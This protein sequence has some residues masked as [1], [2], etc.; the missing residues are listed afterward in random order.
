MS[1]LQRQAQL[2]GTNKPG[3]N[4]R[5]GSKKGS[6]S[7][8]KPGSRSESRAH[9]DVEDDEFQI[10]KFAERMNLSALSQSLDALSLQVQDEETKAQLRKT[11]YQENFETLLKD[12]RSSSL[13]QRQEALERIINHLVSKYDV[14]LYSHGDIET[15]N[16]AITTGR[17]AV[18]MTRAARALVIMALLDIED[19]CEFITSTTLGV[20]EPIISDEDQDPAIRSCLVTCYSLLMYYINLG[21]S[22][23]G[24]EPKIEMLLNIAT[25][26]SSSDSIVSC[27]ALLGIG[28]LTSVTASRNAVI[29]ETLPSIIELLKDND[30]DVRKTAGKNIAL[31]YELY[32]F[33]YQE[34]GTT[35]EDEYSGFKYGIDTVDTGDLIYDLK[36]LIAESAKSIARKTKSELRS[37][38]RKVLCTIEVRLVP[39]D[40]LREDE[41]KD[42]TDNEVAAEAISHLRLSK[43]KAIPI[44]T[45]NQLNLSSILKWLYADGLHTHVANNPLISESISNAGSEHLDRSK[46]NSGNAKSSG[47][48]SFDPNESKFTNK[49][50]SQK[51]EVSIKKGREMKAQAQAEHLQEDLVY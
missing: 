7:S 40:A 2:K 17:S 36:E 29:E 21:N 50:V 10:T 37:V 8:S 30:P 25:E 35:D 18:E 38:F 14:S 20:M 11:S 16:K 6:P 41:L 24:L 34:D 15:L 12:R 5:A 45:W 4:S 43:T 51:R 3:S 22:G 47:D 48:I 31:M 44:D 13:E 1:Y 39:L 9:S 28:L 19:S 49:K 33:S 46:G 42:L 32:D 27:A 26:T 23:F